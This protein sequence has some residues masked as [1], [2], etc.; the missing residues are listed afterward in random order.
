[1]KY[2][3]SRHEDLKSIAFQLGMSLQE[4]DEWGMKSLLKD[5]KLYKKGHSQKIQNLMNSVGGMMEEKFSIFDFKVVVQAGNTP[6]VYW[7][8]AFFVQS[9]NLGLPQM[10]LKPENF[11][12]K[13]GAWLGMQDIDFEEYP[14]FSDKFLLK[15]E[16]KNRIRQTINENVTRFFLVNKEWCMESLGYYMILYRENKLIAP[17][18]IK[19]LYRNGMKIYQELLKSQGDVYL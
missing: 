17:Q 12:H 1:M 4:K 2:P 7:Q 10:L 14:E 16:D 13:I 5:F 19:V 9:K 18:E 15:G 11:F 6:V 8:T 3:K